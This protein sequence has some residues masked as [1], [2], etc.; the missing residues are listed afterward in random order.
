MD[1]PTEQLFW[2]AV[3]VYF[4]QAQALCRE[5][6]E[7][8]IQYYYQTIVPSLLFV[9][10]TSQTILG[11][12]QNFQGRLFVYYNSDRTRPF[13]IPENEMTTFILITSADAANLTYL[14]EDKAEYHV[15]ERVRVIGGPFYGTEGYIKR[16]KK[17]RKLIVSID[18]V[19]AI[20][21]A[22]IPMQFI[23]KI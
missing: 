21:I 4:N 13:A 1:E 22:H 9:H 15:G 20:A 12:K 23:E 7:S 16:I 6:D 14:G 10:C 11:I 2:Y 17:D 5:F 8:G 18:G 3:K 19:A